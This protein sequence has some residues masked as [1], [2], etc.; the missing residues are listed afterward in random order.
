MMEHTGPAWGAFWGRRQLE[1]GQKGCWCLPPHLT[2]Q[3]TATHSS[4]TMAS[5]GAAMA[6]RTARTSAKKKNKRRLTR[7]TDW[8]SGRDTI[9]ITS[10]PMM[11]MAVHVAGERLLRE[12]EFP[13]HAAIN[14]ARP[15]E[16][17]EQGITFV[18]QTKSMGGLTYEVLS[19]DRRGIA[20]LR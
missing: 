11:Q 8:A 3:A 19:T 10:H 2:L 4:Q 6:A 5:A 15:R 16:L 13:R 20:V 9:T 12:D 17:V 7:C 18:P 14:A 1:R